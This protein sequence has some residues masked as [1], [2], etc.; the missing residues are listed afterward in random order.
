MYVSILSGLVATALFLQLARADVAPNLPERGSTFVTNNKTLEIPV[1]W[2]ESG[3][4]PLLPQIVNYTFALCRGPRDDIESVVKLGTNIRASKLSNTTHNSFEAKLSN[5]KALEDDYY[6]IQIVASGKE[7]NTIHYTNIFYLLSEEVYPDQ[8]LLYARPPPPVTNFYSQLKETSTID[9]KSYFVPYL[10]QTGSVKYAP[11]QPLPSKSVKNR[12]N[13]TPL[14]TQT[15]MPIYT[16]IGGYFKGEQQKPFV[17]YTITQ[18]AT[19]TLQ[20]L[21]NTAPYALD[22]TTAYD[23]SE[24]ISS[25]VLKE[26]HTHAKP[27]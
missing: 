8:D 18:P 13:A 19:Y 17:E 1:V 22:P 26:S 5:T 27:S 11:M 21:P 9:T 7:F 24:R 12:W 4:Q 20:T 23:A 6:Y 10:E 2:L 25:P 15:K 14:T 16:K 3:L